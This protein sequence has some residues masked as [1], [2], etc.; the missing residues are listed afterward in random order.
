MQGLWGN[1]AA[2]QHHG[3]DSGPFVPTR[4]P[5]ARPGASPQAAPDGR[6]PRAAGPARRMAHEGEVSPE[7]LSR[8]GAAR[9]GPR[10]G[11]RALQATARPRVPGTTFRAVRRDPSSSPPFIPVRMLRRYPRSSHPVVPSHLSGNHSNSD[12]LSAFFPPSPENTCAPPET[13]GRQ[14]TRPQG[15]IQR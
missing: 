10:A 8:V 4:S 11:Q 5:G 2:S 6:A 1:A 14:V 15:G 7:I 9:R 3:R 13:L 12:G